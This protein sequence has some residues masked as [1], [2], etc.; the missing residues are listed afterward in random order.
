MEQ[1]LKMKQI[2][3]SF[4]GVEV[5]HGV[6]LTLNEGEVLG[7]L[8]ENGAGKSTLMKILMGIESPDAGSI[9]YMGKTLNVQGAAQALK[10][11]ISMVHQELYPILE[12]TVAENIFL[13]R[14]CSK[15]GFSNDRQ[16]EKWAQQW[17][18][19]MG[20]PISPKTKM[21][22]L[23]ISE[24]QMIEITKALSYGAKIIIMDEPTSAITNA[25]VEILFDKILQLKKEKVSVIYISHRL[26]EIERITDRVE[27]LRDGTVAAVDNTKNF[28]MDT[29]IRHMVNRKVTDVYPE[30]QN[31]IGDVMLTVKDLSRLGEFE[32]ISFQLH[33][34]E[35]LGIAGLMGA[36]RSE[37]VHTIFGDRI[38]A[39][40]QIIVQGE[41]VR[42]KCPSDAIKKKI[43]LVTED[44]KAL[45][46]NLGASVKDNGSICIEKREAK[47][48]IFS[49]NKKTKELVDQ[50]IKELSIKVASREQSVSD[51]SGGNQQKVV[52]A[53]WLLNEP[54]IIIFDEPTRGIDVGAKTDIYHLINQLALNGKGVIVISSELPE[55]MGITDRILVLSE[56]KLTGEL[57]RENF[58]SE[59]I[60]QFASGI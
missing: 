6:D 49:N 39:S 25:E 24:M 44:R 26:D 32:N 21:K 34:G 46:L 20:L 2:F 57:T 36:G 17:L 28:D 53:K 33:S 43:A 51:L 4:S 31:Q 22:E 7:L 13:G 41:K 52:L 38:P 30:F 58:D 48:K 35:R 59:V 45:G 12:M 8:G 5:L 15:L 56:G 1:I 11:G 37:L 14:E 50:M 27:I 55:L 3:K 60:M 23:S 54:D 29:I 47:W 40:G 18:D 19:K 16:Q 42:F 10:A 9:E